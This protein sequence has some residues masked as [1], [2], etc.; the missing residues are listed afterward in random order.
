[1]RRALA[2]LIVAA[3]NLIG[4]AAY[5]HHSISSTYLEDKT[6]T[7]EGELVQLLFRNPH[8]FV[9]MVVRDKDGR[10]VRYAIEWGGANQLGVQG[11]SRDTLK[12][13]DR[14]I[15]HGNPARNQRDHRVRMLTLERPRDGFGWGRKPGEVVE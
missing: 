13:G 12:I 7:I 10:P 3:S 1:M 4:A 2:I 8:S 11:L 9:H 6:V 15:V 5:A 14:L